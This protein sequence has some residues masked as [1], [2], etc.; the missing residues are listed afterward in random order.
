MF[1]LQLLTH[2]GV[3]IAYCQFV[4]ATLSVNVTLGM[5]LI[6]TCDD[7][8]ADGVSNLEMSIVCQY[9]C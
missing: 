7:G 3:V 6:A 8:R 9:L 2:V 4:D 1:L 5:L